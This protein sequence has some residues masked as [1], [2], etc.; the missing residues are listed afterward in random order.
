MYTILGAGGTIANEFSKVLFQNNVPHTLV[1]RN[2][3]SI[4]G[5]LTLA[6]DLTNESEAD[7]AVK[8]ATIV[9]LCPGLRYDIRI[10]KEKWPLIMSNTIKACIRYNV[11]LIFFDNVF[12]SEKLLAP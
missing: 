12:L 3:N 1:S 6:A 10:W 8:G 7:E 9:L 5:A 2:P 4:N 11:K